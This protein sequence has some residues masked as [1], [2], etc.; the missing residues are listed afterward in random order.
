MTSSENSVAS[1][2]RRVRTCTET[3]QEATMERYWWL[4][5]IPTGIYHCSE[6]G[7]DVSN[8]MTSHF[9]WRSEGVDA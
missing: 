5:I 2:E 6:C 3:G 1:G 8:P 4:S 7:E 9:E